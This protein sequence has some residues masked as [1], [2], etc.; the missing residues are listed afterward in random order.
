MLQMLLTKVN[1]Q[2]DLPKLS[3]NS[4]RFPHPLP[5]NNSPLQVGTFK[6]D[7]AVSQQ[8]QVSD[9]HGSRIARRACVPQQRPQTPLMFPIFSS[10]HARM[11]C[12][13]SSSLHLLRGLSRES[14]TN[15]R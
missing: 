14:I 2:A 11:I 8:A 9:W 1:N 5:K 12:G 7:P 10:R 4:A 3:A 15:A 6:L 13:R